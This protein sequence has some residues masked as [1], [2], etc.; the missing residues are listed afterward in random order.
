M[1]DV[2]KNDP[3]AIS[4]RVGVWVVP[5]RFAGSQAV[6]VL[7]PQGRHPCVQLEVGEPEY[8]RANLVDGIKQCCPGSRDRITMARPTTPLIDKEVAVKT[9]LELIDSEGLDAFSMRHL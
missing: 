3:L 8:D 5:A 4:P 9:A 7:V 6:M 1:W 2:R